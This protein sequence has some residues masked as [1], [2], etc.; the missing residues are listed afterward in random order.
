MSLTT[1]S[2]ILVGLMLA[3]SAIMLASSLAVKKLRTIPGPPENEGEDPVMFPAETRAGRKLH[4]ACF[5]NN[6]D[7]ANEALTQWAWASGETGV[8][9]SLNRKME[10]LCR[11]ELR[12]AVKELWEHLENHDD[13]PWFGDKLWN[14]FVGTHPEFQKMECSG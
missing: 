11:P 13:R 10:A 5:D 9:N 14:A 3:V 7:A 8:A 6:A 1:L 2:L 12:T 4:Q